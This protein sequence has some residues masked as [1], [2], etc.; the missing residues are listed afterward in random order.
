MGEERKSAWSSLEQRMMWAK[1][2][3][4]SAETPSVGN[5][6]NLLRRNVG[7]RF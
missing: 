5:D 7:V 6:G 2:E 4:E 1:E 3:R